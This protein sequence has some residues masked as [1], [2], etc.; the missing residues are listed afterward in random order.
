LKTIIAGIDIMKKI[1]NKSKQMEICVTLHMSL[2]ILMNNQI[3]VLRYGTRD[4]PPLNL[5]TDLTSH[6][7][8]I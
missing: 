3:H 8:L 1:S 7:V 6:P 5:E 4:L 2:E